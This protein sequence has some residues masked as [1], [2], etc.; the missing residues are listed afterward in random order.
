MKMYSR[1]LLFSL[2]FALCCLP[3]LYAQQAAMVT[4][5]GRVIS[6]EDKQPLIG[7]S[8]VT[9]DMQGVATDVD[10]KYSIKAKSGSALTFSYL[11]FKNIEWRVPKDAS[12]V[13]YNVEMETD[14]ESIDDVVVIAYG[15]RKKGTVAGSV[16]S[17][18]TEK[19]ESTPTAAFDQAL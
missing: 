15:T 6:A 13:Q 10:G 12:S 16:A 7:V 5:S 1:K 2:I 8:V 19:I 9:E 14:S 18:K 17:V 3:T 4:V 11:G